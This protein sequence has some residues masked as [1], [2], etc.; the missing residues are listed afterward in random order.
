VLYPLCRTRLLLEQNLENFKSN[1]AVRESLTQANQ[2]MAVLQERL[3]ALYG[4]N[5]HLSD[6]I[7][8]YNANVDLFNRHLP[9]VIDA[10][11]AEVLAACNEDIKTVRGL[12]KK[13]GFPIR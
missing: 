2:Q 4:P 12:I 13:A 10:P 6:N 11:S 7:R 1:P 8:L 5:F 3:A 9:P